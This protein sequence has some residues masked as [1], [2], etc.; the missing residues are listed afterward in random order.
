MG[1][2]GIL[3]IGRIRLASAHDHA[4][5]H[6]R[7]VGQGREVVACST[8]QRH[9][10]VNLRQATRRRQLTADDYDVIAGVQAN[11]KR[12]FARS[13]HVLGWAIERYE[14][15]AVCS[16]DLNVGELTLLFN[17]AIVA[18]QQSRFVRGLKKKR[19]F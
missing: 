3:Q 13:A 5:L 9:L 11:G 8:K 14:R 1:T 12:R 10:V 2:L 18:G 17:W 6:A 7:G 4:E 19:K 15:G 16:R